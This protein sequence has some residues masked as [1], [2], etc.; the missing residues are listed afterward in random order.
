MRT[1]V[2]DLL[3]GA[4]RLE[5]PSKG[6]RV[7]MDSVLLAS[8]ARLRRGDSVFE[9]GCGSGAILLI[10]AWR[11]PEIRSL[12]GIEIQ[13]EMA[14]M[15]RRNAGINGME[16]R[17]SVITGDLRNLRRE[18]EGGS[19]SVVVGNPPYDEKHRSR[20]SPVAGEAVSRHG[21]ACTLEDVLAGASW[22]LARK[23]RFYTVFR[24]RRMGELIGGLLKVQLQPKRLRLV[25]PDPS[26]EASVVL[27]ESVKQG[28][29][30]MMVEPPLWI[31]D[32]RGAFSPEYL[33]AYTREGWPCP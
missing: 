4:L 8:F 22:S 21:A 7:N 11:H 15:A 12:E 18:T 28:G 19:Y 5:Q 13:E 14:D 32:A 2:N 6:Y 26:S 31:R 33:F 10:L 3:Y 1:T 30:G 9:L 24:A 29:A 23:G 17:I 16:Q 27:V 20:P 25:Y